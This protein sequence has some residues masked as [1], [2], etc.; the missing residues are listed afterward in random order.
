MVSLDDIKN[1][2]LYFNNHNVFTLMDAQQ[3]E[4][5]QFIQQ[6]NADVFLN[7]PVDDIIDQVVD[8]YA[9]DVPVFQRDQAHLEEPREV[10]LTIQDYGRT[11]HPMG[12][13]LTLVVPFTGDTGR[14]IALWVSA[15]EILAHP[16]Y[17]KQNGYKQVYALLNSV[18]SRNS[19]CKEKRFSPYPYK[20]GIRSILPCWIYGQLNGIRN[21]FLHGNRV[22]DDDLITKRSQRGIQSYA[23]VL[24][25]MALAAF[26]K[27]KFTEKLKAAPS[28]SVYEQRK[29]EFEA[30]QGDAES[31]LGSIC[32]T[33]QEWNN[34]QH[35]QLSPNVKKWP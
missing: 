23:S 4:A 21:D 10:R 30:H 14:I 20:Q 24:Y 31:A 33:E 1:A 3:K 27:L 12:T 11:I 26:L 18:K 7:T 9:F 16:P 5:A 13:V 29:F 25:R 32:Y 35:G 15:F 6:M 8:K 34:I 19:R 28:K 17:G 2:V 22:R